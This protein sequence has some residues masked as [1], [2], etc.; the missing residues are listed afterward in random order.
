MRRSLTGAAVLP[1]FL[2]LLAHI[3]FPTI[4]A[5]AADFE[6]ADLEA[7]RQDPFLCIC[8]DFDTPL[9]SPDLQRQMKRRY[10]SAFFAPWRQKQP[11]RGIESLTWGFF[12]Y[13]KKETFGENRRR[14]SPEWFAKQRK[15]AEERLFGTENRPAI[16]VC[17]ADLRI[18]PAADPLFFDFDEAGEGYPFDY[19]QNSVVKPGEPLFVSHRSADGAWFFVDAPTASGWIDARRIGLMDSADVLLFSAPD[20]IV[21]ITDDFPLTDESGV[22]LGRAKTGSQFPLLETDLLHGS[23]RVR[24]PVRRTDGGIEAGSALVPMTDA[25]RGVLPLT[26]WNGALVV[27]S[28]LAEPYGWGGLHGRRDCSALVMDFFAPFGIRMPRNSREQAQNGRWI[29]LK[30]KD[31]E[32]KERILLKE[33]IPFRT[34]V[35]M[36]GHIMLYIGQRR[37]R[38]L[39]FHNMW[40]VRTRGAGRPGRHIVGKA[41]ITTLAPGMELPDYDGLPGDRVTGLAIIGESCAGE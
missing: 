21:L 26:P 28:L 18:F 10:D 16:A 6:I 32:E 35:A 15:N 25:I 3:L 7:F 38:P 22:Y 14:R 11:G 33:G 19:G 5:S 23:F 2:V 36:P 8:G 29:D 31:L 24:V 40:G 17:E 9:L 39:V 41:V 1:L 12:T 27:S 37:G 20:R 34:L 4:P 13:G 30:G